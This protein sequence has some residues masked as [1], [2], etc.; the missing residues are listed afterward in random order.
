MATQAIQIIGLQDF[1]EPVNLPTIYRGLT[2][3]PYQISLANSDGTPIDLTGATI[4]CGNQLFTFFINPINL[5]GG[6]F[7]ILQTGATTATYPIGKYPYDMTAPPI[8]S[9]PI[10]GGFVSVK[11]AQ[12]MQQPSSL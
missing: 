11:Q 2:W 9:K 5:T 8:Q 4:T 10:F 3:G 6:V 7:Q 12:S 1:V